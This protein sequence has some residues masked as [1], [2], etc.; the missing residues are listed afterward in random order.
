MWY[1]D[2]VKGGNR[3]EKEKELRLT[4][5]LTQKE[6]AEFLGVSISLIQKI[7]IGNKKITSEFVKLIKDKEKE[8][9]KKI[10]YFTYKIFLEE[11]IT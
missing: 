2:I 5:G 7:E 3:V 4:L 11:L 1:N 10:P 9:Q 6:M 8:I